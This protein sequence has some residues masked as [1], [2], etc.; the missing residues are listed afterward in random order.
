MRINVTQ[1]CRKGFG[2]FVDLLF[3]RRCA[4][5]DRPVKLPGTWFC[6]SCEKDLP[7]ITGPRCEKC[8]R[9]LSFSRE[10]KCENC[11][12]HPH[13]FSRGTAAFV[14]Q[15]VQMPVY[16]FKYGSR[17]EYAK[18]FSLAMEKE[19]YRV[20]SREETDC[21]IPVPLHENRLKT[22]GYNQAA[23]LAR[24][25][26]ERCKIPVEEEVLIRARDTDPLKEQTPAERRKNL[27]HAFR[28]NRLSHRNKVQ[29]K[30]I[31][32]VDD[33]FTTG[34]TVD[35]CAAA[36]LDAGAAK[37]CFLSLSVSVEDSG[38]PGEINGQRRQSLP[39]DANGA[40]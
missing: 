11:R 18:A 24:E 12:R 23:L 38:K 35:A 39:D 9:P 4:I 31:L 33:I 21:L 8:G 26:S 15:D 13:L 29:S 14:Y 17:A 28:I 36:L 27:S 7:K 2:N 10:N 1:A 3:P 40:V 5:C 34:A 37:G 32:L 30:N 19:Y 22:R 25:L 6:P 16:R 20:F